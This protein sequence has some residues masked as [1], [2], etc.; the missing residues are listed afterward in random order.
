MLCRSPRWEWVSA[1]TYLTR[2]LS[3]KIAK[4]A[5]WLLYK[6]R[7]GAHCRCNM[8]NVLKTCRNEKTQSAPEFFLQHCA[9]S[10]VCLGIGENNLL[11]DRRKIQN[12]K[13]YA[14]RK[15]IDQSNNKNG[16]RIPKSHIHVINGQKSKLESWVVCSDK[17]RRQKN[18]ALYTKM[19]SSLSGK[20]T[21]HMWSKTQRKNIRSSV[22][23]SPLLCCRALPVAVAVAVAVVATARHKSL[24]RDAFAATSFYTQRLLRIE[25]FTHRSFHT[26][27][28]FTHRSLYPQ[29]L[30]H[31]EA[32]THRSFY[33]Q[34]LL[35]RS[36]YTEAFTH[37]SLYTRKLLH[38]NAFTYFYTQK[39]LC[40]KAFTHRTFYTQKPLHTEA[41][42]HRSFCTQK[43]LHRGPFTHRSFYTQDLLHT[44]SFYT[45]KLLHREA[46]THTSVIATSRLA[47]LVS[48]A[49]N[50]CLRPPWQQPEGPA[51]CRKLSNK[52]PLF[53]E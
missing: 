53:L 46:F 25:A 9:E 39:L 4:S 47:N 12:F 6:K 8:T 36:F 40:T 15:T 38:T 48:H 11:M 50:P 37:R 1:S 21:Y 17:F 24:H 5:Q 22:S 2:W 29:K 20:S 30:L 19:V 28:L 7:D 32:F 35:H 13:P 16:V 43:L 23:R 52:S 3:N 33:T 27:E 14:I 10:I 44:E 42:T 41:F 26:Q 18:G 49:N 45:Q 51:E 31:T 34:K